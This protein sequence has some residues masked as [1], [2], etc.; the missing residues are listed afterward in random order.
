MVKG[1]LRGLSSKSKFGTSSVGN[2]IWAFWIEYNDWVLNQ[3]QWH[4][5]KV[6]HLNWSDL[7]LY[8]KVV[9]ERVVHFVTI[10]AL[11]IDALF[12]GFNDT[13]RN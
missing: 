13:W 7:I 5:F 1:S 2:T 12:K 3:E 9:W 4:K 6:K 10:T 11:S 8:A